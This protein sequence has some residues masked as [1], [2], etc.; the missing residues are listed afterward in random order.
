MSVEYK[1]ALI[2]G[3]D[4]THC[5]DDFSSEIR[6]KWEEAGWDIIEDCYNDDFLY[7]GK[8][9]SNVSLGDEVIIDCECAA[10]QASIYLEELLD[11]TSVEWKLL[12]PLF[13]ST[14]HICY[15]K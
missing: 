12:L 2:Y 8:I 1:A 3:F 5:I 10:Q 7:I 14:Y 9:I 11:K 6:E 4:C 15:A 13:P